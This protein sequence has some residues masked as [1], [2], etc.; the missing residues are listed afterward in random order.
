[1][2]KTATYN[3]WTVLGHFQQGVLVT[4]AIVNLLCLGYFVGVQAWNEWRPGPVRVELAQ[5]AFNASRNRYE[6]VLVSPHQV[7]QFD[8]VYENP[9]A[10]SAQAAF[11][12]S[13]GNSTG[14]IPSN[15]LGVV[16][17]T[18]TNPVDASGVAA[19]GATTYDVANSTYFAGNSLVTYFGPRAGCVPRGGGGCQASTLP[20]GSRGKISIRL[21]LKQNASTI[22][23]TLNGG[24]YLN[25]LSNSYA[26]LP[27]TG[28]QIQTNYQKTNRVLDKS[29][30]PTVAFRGENGSGSAYAGQNYTVVVT[31]LKGVNGQNLEAPNGICRTTR[32]GREFAVTGISNGSCVIQVSAPA[33][34]ANPGGVLFVS[35]GG[36]PRSQSQN[37]NYGGGSSGSNPNNFRATIQ[38]VRFNGDRSLYEAD[39]VTD[40]FSNGTG[41]FHTN[42]YYNSEPDTTTNKSFSGASPYRTPVNG[43]PGNATELCVVVA[44]PNNTPFSGSGNCAA[45]PSFEVSTNRVA[46]AREDIEPIRF[47]C[48]TGVQNSRTTCEFTIPPDRFLPENFGMAVG[49]TIVTSRCAPIGQKILC[50]DV[51]IGGGQG[52]VDIFVFFGNQSVRTGE[53]MRLEPGGFSDNDSDDS[54][55]VDP[56]VDPGTDLDPDFEDDGGPDETEPNLIDEEGVATVSIRRGDQ[57]ATP[58]VREIERIEEEPARESEQVAEVPGTETVQELDELTVPG[59]DRPQA[60]DLVTT[61]GATFFLLSGLGSIVILAI[62]SASLT[63]P[64]LPSTGNV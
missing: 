14:D 45:L 46:L 44:G 32:S 1:M 31:N 20:A 18:D 37:Y 35:D 36:S 56:G 38:G 15:L 2:S 50:Q 25:F 59:D 47:S 26:D 28:W 19:A 30:A 48:V 10:A 42:F 8:Y 41:G 55:P 13:L 21:A 11:E 4:L 7:A 62:F 3:F 40:N 43:K 52:K 39:F 5:A 12:L 9:H 16:S 60:T 22:P 57:D 33:E 54:G 17:V 49:N 6:D 61:G 24:G 63:R 64:V 53:T 34:E 51:S 58:S 27:P 23:T 29:I